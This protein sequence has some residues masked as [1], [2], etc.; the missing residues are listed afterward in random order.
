MNEQSDQNL[1]LNIGT[2][3]TQQSIYSVLM[4][5][6]QVMRTKL[7]AGIRVQITTSGIEAC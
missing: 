7:S 4:Q 6:K 1:Y 2:I 3:K 5:Y